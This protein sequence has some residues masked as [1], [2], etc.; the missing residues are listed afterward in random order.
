MATGTVNSLV[1]T[2]NSNLS[3]Y[4]TITLTVDST[5]A[6]G[7][8]S[9]I[10][11][12]VTFMSRIQIDSRS[13]GA[14]ETITLCTLPEGYRPPFPINFVV[15]TNARDSVFRCIVTQNGAVNVYNPAGAT[16]LS[17]LPFAVSFLV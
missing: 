3:N 13:W 17:L 6:S 15:P 7:V 1:S 10:G 16:T 2:L 11:H 4:N 5:T 12:Q 8:Y 9:R 14:Y